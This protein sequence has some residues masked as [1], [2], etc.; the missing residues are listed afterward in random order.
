MRPFKI[1]AFVIALLLSV[2]TNAA[3]ETPVELCD[4]LA[5][6][7]EDLPPGITKGVQFFW[8]D[9][10]KAIPPCIIA[11]KADRE[12]FRIIH[13]MGRAILLKAYA[14]R[15]SLVEKMIRLMDQ[16]AREGYAPSAALLG[17]LYSRNAIVKKDSHK[18]FEYYTLAKS[19]GSK[20]GK[21]NVARM[22]VMGQIGPKDE[23]YLGEIEELAKAGY[24]L[25][26]LYLGLHLGQKKDFFT[27]ITWNKLAHKN[28]LAQAA[29]NLH[30]IYAFNRPPY[31]PK[32]AIDWLLTAA[33]MGYRNA[34]GELGAYYE[35]GELVEKD[36]LKAILYYTKEIEFLTKFMDLHS[37]RFFADNQIKHFGDKIKKLSKL[38]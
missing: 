22:H 16:S 4:R 10:E 9:Y 23:S 35:T 37:N 12:N 36:R 34:Y 14:K 15:S 18:A 19:L 8:I 7:E 27:S 1:T 2:A 3:A 11:F 6:D 20:S 26:Q 32:K 30:E 33:K 13:Q 29:H 31:D 38:K 21:Y 24:G 28:G 5:A 17:D 25:A